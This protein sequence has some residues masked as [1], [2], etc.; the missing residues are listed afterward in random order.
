[1]KS[2]YATFSV[3]EWKKLRHIKE[4]AAELT[5]DKKPPTWEDFII[6]ASEALA[7]MV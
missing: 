5:A 2:I 4:K 6:M 7:V 3:K 1:M